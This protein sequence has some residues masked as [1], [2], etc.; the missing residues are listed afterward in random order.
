[1]CAIQCAPIRS[2]SLRGHSRSSQVNP[3]QY[4]FYSK[5]G[6]FNYHLRSQ[7]IYM[8]LHDM[9]WPDM[10]ICNLL[11]CFGPGQISPSLSTFVTY[12]VFT[13]NHIWHAVTVDD[14]WCQWPPL[15]SFKF[16]Q[17]ILGHFHAHLV[18]QRPHKDQKTRIFARFWPF[19]LIWPWMTWPMENLTSV[20]KS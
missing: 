8:T 18:S 19:D 16:N 6:S 2:R 4:Y 12:C 11:A 17:T 13:H 9:I 1:M 7:W 3:W 15:T 14:L 10:T 5:M 20:Y